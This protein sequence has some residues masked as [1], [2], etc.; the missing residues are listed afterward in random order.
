MEETEDDLSPIEQMFLLRTEQADMRN[1]RF[2]TR[3]GGF[4][5]YIAYRMFAFGETVNPNLGQPRFD[6]SETPPSPSGMMQR[7]EQ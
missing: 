6:V 4:S 1:R 5:A 2:G 7:I 3:T